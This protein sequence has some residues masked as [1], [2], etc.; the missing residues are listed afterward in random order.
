LAK[1]QADKRIDS[2]HGWTLVAQVLLA[3]LAAVVALIGAKL[4]PWFHF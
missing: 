2:R 1:K 3:L 4:I